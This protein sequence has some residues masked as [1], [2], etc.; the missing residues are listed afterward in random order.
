MILY[1]RRINLPEME[2]DIFYR[3]QTL[4]F[5]STLLTF[6]ISQ[7]AIAM[8]KD[9]Y[10]KEQFIKSPGIIVTE[11]VPSSQRQFKLFDEEIK[12]SKT[13]GSYGY[14]TNLKTDKLHQI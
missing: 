5:P 6:T 2:N 11:I 7:M 4:P 12:I 3:M 10:Q 1:L 9:L 8:L 14:H 13:Y